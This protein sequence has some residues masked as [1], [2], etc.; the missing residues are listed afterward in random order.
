ML[1][2]SVAG[3]EEAKRRLGRDFRGV[4]VSDIR[5]PRMDGMAIPDQQL[6]LR[7]E[8]PFHPCAAVEYHLR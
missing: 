4:I 3:A 8:K 6:E 1:T 7:G 5:L 2:E